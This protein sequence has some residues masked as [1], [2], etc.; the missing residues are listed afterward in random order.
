MVLEF[1]F[2][3]ETVDAIDSPFVELETIDDEL[4]ESP[5]PEAIDEETEETL[6][7]NPS[8]TIAILAPNE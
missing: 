3:G 2:L 7:T 5:A 1:Q 4:V 8:T 6:G